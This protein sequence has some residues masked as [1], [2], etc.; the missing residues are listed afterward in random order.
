MPPDGM[1]HR[2]PHSN[3]GKEREAGGRRGPPV[4]IKKMQPKLSIPAAKA[5]VE[6]AIEALNFDNPP[7]IEGYT[8]DVDM[9]ALQEK[10]FD[11]FS[12]QALRGN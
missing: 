4:F 10:I 2:L 3:E 12:D 5:A 6:A 11:K 1:T 8:G 9:V 7:N